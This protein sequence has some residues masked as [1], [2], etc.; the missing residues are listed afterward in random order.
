[1]LFFVTGASGSGKTAVLP[2]LR[3]LLP[4]M[5]I[6]DFDDYPQ[7]ERIGQLDSAEQR[8]RVA[9]VWLQTAMATRPEHTVVSGL[10]VMGEVLACP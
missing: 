1:M 4:D 5:K 2:A 6:H 8:Q 10:G 9:E 7:R 3:S